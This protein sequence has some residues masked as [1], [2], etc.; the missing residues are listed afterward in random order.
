[1]AQGERVELDTT[2]ELFKPNA[3]FL[4]KEIEVQRGQ[5]GTSCSKFRKKLGL[6]LRNWDFYCNE[7]YDVFFNVPFNM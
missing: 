3:S 4:I 1:M 5:S 2:L 7:T 6:E